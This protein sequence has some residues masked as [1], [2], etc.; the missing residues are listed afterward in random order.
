[1]CITLPLLYK[2]ALIAYNDTEDWEKA[3]NFYTA[4]A[5][6]ADTDDK[7]FEAR[8]GAL[9]CAYKLE[10]AEK[11][12]VSGEAVLDHGRVTDDYS[13][14]AHYYM[15]SMAYVQKNYE[16]ALGS[17]NAVIRINSADLAAEARYRI[18]SV[19]E[20]Q[21]E[22]ELAAKLAEEAA[23]ANV[24]YPEWVAKSLLLLSKIQ[25]QSGDLLNARA[26]LEA[27]IEN[28]QGNEEIIA[29]ANEQL[30]IVKKEE[31]RVSR[32]KPQ[33]GETL[34]LQPNPKQD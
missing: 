29:E 10:D 19:Y 25:F 22:H 9:R 4:Y 34:E 5:P 12:F 7:N 13:A 28:F 31:E 18:A 14:L 33:S 1:M 2:A 24:G 23:R 27:I 32:I 26:I 17:F 3:Y 21:G 15:A 16:K 6:L 30:I 8:L 20:E 11:V